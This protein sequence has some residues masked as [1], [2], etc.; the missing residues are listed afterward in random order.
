MA[1][2]VSYDRA[3][4]PGMSLD[5]LEKFLGEIRDQPSW[6]RVADRECAYYD[7][8]QLDSKTLAAMER[9]G[10]P[11]LVTN[12][13]A[14]TV[15][16]LLGMEAKTRAD[17]RVAADTEDDQDFAE[18][19]S[20]KLKE[21]E[22]ESYADNACSDAY[23]GQV[24]AGLHWVEVNREMD[25]FKY[26]YLVQPVHRNEIFWDWKAKRRDMDDARYLVRKQWKDV[27]ILK[28]QFKRHRDLID[29]LQNFD[30]AGWDQYVGRLG[31]DFARA[32]DSQFGSRLDRSEWWNNE[33]KQ[34]CVYEVWYRVWDTAWVMKLPDG[35][36]MELDLKNPRHATAVLQNMVQPFEANFSRMRLSYWLG[37][38]RVE[39][40]AAK[41]N[42][43]PYVPFWGKREDGTG[44][45]YGLIRSMMSP[46]DEIN[47]R[48]AKAM[49]MMS[50]RRVRVEGDAV[51]DHD[52][53]RRELARPDAYIVLNE[54]RKNQNGK[55]MEVDDNVEL[56]EQQFKVREER[57]Q[58]LQAA[59]GV[60][61]QMLGNSEGGGADS[62]V[63]IASL[64]E[65]G[66]ITQAELNDNYRFARRMVYEYLLEFVREDIKPNT[67]VEIGGQ[68]KPKKKVLLNVPKKDQF[69]NDFLEN[70]VQRDLFKVAL[71]DVP[72]TPAYRAQMLQ[73]IAEATKGMPPQAQA[74]MAPFLLRASDLP[75]RHRMADMLLKVLGMPADENADPEKDKMQQIIQQLQGAL[76]QAEQALSD[77]SDF[78]N[79]KLDV[80]R[81]KVRIAASDAETRRIA[82]KATVSANETSAAQQLISMILAEARNAGAGAT[83]TA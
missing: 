42:H 54:G 6:R 64:V 20:I 82:A 75:D 80:E 15:D 22:R 65:Q 5:E 58:S 68:G 81:Q 73:R 46:Q 14:P 27:D 66:S 70:S 40:I 72:S 18:A 4:K 30:R 19:L 48:D 25:P 3:N 37:P 50:S 78:E 12:L 47:A 45:P 21:A 57:K 29:V 55:G 35:R 44:I 51:K 67:E 52:K 24:K 11:P 28:R 56:S 41:R 7:G 63:A 71:E 38:H 16:V 31:G 83:A 8:N 13:I 79:G 77:K 53:A 76:S 2:F 62:G 49:W 1:D 43:F 61:Q 23:A 60:Y 9:I 26:P 59:A 17:A 36:T 32:Y 33:R 39:D 69:G 34:I 10:I 74:I